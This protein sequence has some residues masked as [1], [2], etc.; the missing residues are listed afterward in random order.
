MASAHPSRRTPAPIV[1]LAAIGVGLIALPLLGLAIR[2]PWG[3]IGEAVSGDTALTALRLSI[4]VAS[5]AA[6][7]SLAFG[8]PLAWVLART[9][10]RGKALVR[11]A[12][13]LPLVM[14]P[15]VAG[16]ALLAAFGRRGRSGLGSSTGSASR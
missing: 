11:T 8:F 6:V 4:V 14:P 5:A 15:V 16:V 1:V 3:R 13:V 10:F 9:E 2:V 12:V 7:L